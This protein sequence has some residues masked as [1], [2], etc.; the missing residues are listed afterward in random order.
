RSEALRPEDD[1]GRHLARLAAHSNELLCDS[2][3]AQQFVTLFCAIVDLPQGR[4]HYVNAGHNPPLLRLPNAAPAFIE[5]PRNPLVGLVPGLSYAVDSC[6]FPAGSLLLLYTDGV[7]E[8]EC[9]DGGL[10]SDETLHRLLADNNAAD[11]DAA[12]NKSSPRWTLLPP[13]TPNPTT[14]PCWPSTAR[15][16]NRAAFPTPPAVDSYAPVS[17][18]PGQANLIAF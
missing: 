12:W 4:L 3:E 11:A 14:S 15:P 5:G 18:R 10:F 7:T 16:P 2:N 13:A 6:D 8:A 1:A 9:A 17:G